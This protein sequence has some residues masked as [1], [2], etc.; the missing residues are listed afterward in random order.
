MSNIKKV[1][2]RKESTKQYIDALQ[3]RYSKLCIVRLDLGYKKDKKS[4]KVEVSLDEAN[5]DYNHMMNNKRSKP[6]I[7]KDQVGQLCLKEYTPN[8]G[9]HYHTVFIYDGNKVQKGEYKADQI[10]GYWRQITNEKG[11]YHNCH[12]NTY[13]RDGLGILDYK[14]TEKRKIVDKDVISYLLK[15]DEKQDISS[16][17][18]NKKDRAFTRG[19]LPKS[20]GNIGRPRENKKIN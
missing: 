8:K 9:V 17:K 2:K 11:S 12:R 10:G 20:K 4:K 3:E 7:F 5:T 13:K 19:T 14:D 16:I 6:S 15:D 18:T 1:N